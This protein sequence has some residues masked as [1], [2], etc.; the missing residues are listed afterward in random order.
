LKV[1]ERGV[2]KLDSSLG[3]V[4]GSTSKGIPVGGYFDMGRGEKKPVILL[5]GGMELQPQILGGGSACKEKGAD[6]IV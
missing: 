5:V 6:H 1:L 3:A 4:V 2:S